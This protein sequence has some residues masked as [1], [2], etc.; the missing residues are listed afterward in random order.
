MLVGTSGICTTLAA[1]EAGLSERWASTKRQSRL[2]QKSL[3]MG[4]RPLG[5]PPLG[6]SQDALQRECQELL[7]PESAASSRVGDLGS[8]RLGEVPET[9]R[10]GGQMC[11]QHLPRSLCL[12]DGVRGPG[13][14]KPGSVSSS[15]IS[16][17]ES[18]AFPEGSHQASVP[19]VLPARESS[20]APCTK[21]GFGDTG[22]CGSE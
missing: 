20:T 19:R 17:A 1:S 4:D 21:R 9:I 13:R 11:F 3:R 5:Q 7:N 16:Q 2:R 22:N 10:A 15:S 8:K 18:R 14:R 6:V 12:V